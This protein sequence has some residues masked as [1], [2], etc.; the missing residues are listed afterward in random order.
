[1]SMLT[2]TS[3]VGPN[4]SE[5]QRDVAAQKDQGAGIEDRGLLGRIS[6]KVPDYAFP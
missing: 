6:S 2:G 4:G 1:M 5:T 3:M